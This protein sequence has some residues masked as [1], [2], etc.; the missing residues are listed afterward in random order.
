[1]RRSMAR[2][3]IVGVAMTLSGCISHATHRVLVFLQKRLGVINY[4]N[5]VSPVLS[6]IE[7]KPKVDSLMSVFECTSKEIRGLSVM[8]LF[9]T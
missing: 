5:A 9:K 4:Q 7:D 3:F 8:G 2:L 1:M 6:E